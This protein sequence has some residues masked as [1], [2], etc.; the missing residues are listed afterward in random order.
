[1]PSPTR[2]LIVDDHFALRLGL[3]VAVD[4]EADM[5]VV[6]QGASVADAVALFD[7]HKPDVVLMDYSLPDGTGIEALQ[8][9]RSVHAAARVLMLTILDGEEDVFRAS[10]A[11]ACGYLT[12]SADSTTV[13]SAIRAIAAG[14]V[15]FPEEAKVKIQTRERR[16][17]L[18]PRELEILHRIVDG[19]S[20]KEIG[21]QLGIT[22]GTVKL[23]VAK[24][25]AKTGAADRTRAAI[26]AVERGIVRLSK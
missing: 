26:L 9:I 19:M 25:L 11:G 13:I 22:E 3:T 2:V 15:F 5:K 18:S 17:P 16:D 12:K 8:R 7:Q 21:W 6:A 23:H 24:V 1:M 20:N 10:G 4:N 14:G